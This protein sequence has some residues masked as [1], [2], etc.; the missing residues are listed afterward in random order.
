VLGTFGTVGAV[1]RDRGSTPHAL[2]ASNRPSPDAHR[3]VASMS[4]ILPPF[5]YDMQGVGFRPQVG[6]A[7]STQI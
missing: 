5:Q 2:I 3:I 1:G 6:V 7:E 4:L